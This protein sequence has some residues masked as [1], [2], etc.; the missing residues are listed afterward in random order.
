MTNQ[1][2]DTTG[3]EPPPG[4]RPGR[5]NAWAIRRLPDEISLPPPRAVYSPRRRLFSCGA[6]EPAGGRTVE[7]SGNNIIIIT[8]YQQFK[9]FIKREAL[10]PSRLA[11]AAAGSVRPPRVAFP[12]PYGCFFRSRGKSPRRPC[13]SIWRGLFARDIFQFS[14]PQYAS[15]GR[16]RNLR[17]E[18]ILLHRLRTRSP[19][20]CA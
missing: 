4:N 3:V 2:A 5:S 16:N 9:T 15:S 20:N 12:R 7:K 17:K 14:Y 11:P 13:I 8:I 10:Q 18:K 19:K 6:A 1:P